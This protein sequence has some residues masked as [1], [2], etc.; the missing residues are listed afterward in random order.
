M[1]DVIKAE[2]SQDETVIIAE[3][4][5]L[6]RFMEFAAEE[7]VEGDNK[8][9]TI[10]KQDVVN[11]DLP[12]CVAKVEPSPPLEGTAAVTDY[13]VAADLQ[14]LDDKVKSMVEVSENHVGGAPG[15]GFNR[16]CKVC[17][18]EGLM[19]HIRDHIEATHITGVS[20]TCNICGDIRKTRDSMR[21][22]MKRHKKNENT[23]NAFVKNFDTKKYTE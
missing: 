21:M 6:K 17:G 10:Q 19:H 18:K 1:G 14:D 8:L 7:E 3:E 4:L 12:N 23:Y 22:H 16:I 20:H 5:Q 15:K 2:P 11:P 13:T 9:T